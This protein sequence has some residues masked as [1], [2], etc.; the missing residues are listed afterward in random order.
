MIGDAV[1]T[2][3]PDDLLFRVDAAAAEWSMS[4]AE[5][6]RQAARDALTVQAPRFTEGRRRSP[7]ELARIV[8]RDAGWGWDGDDQLVDEDGELVAYTIEDSAAAMHDLGWFAPA[9]AGLAW[10]DIPHAYLRGAR[11]AALAERLDAGGR[12]P[13]VNR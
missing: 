5:W 2:R 10:S 4:R 12:H 11:A 6:L 1:T 7:T 13:Q 9:G 3:L 8:A